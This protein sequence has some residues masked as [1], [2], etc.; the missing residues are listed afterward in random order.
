MS[1]TRRSILTLLTA[2]MVTLSLSAR[3]S[4]A[5]QQEVSVT[6]SLP[7]TAYTGDTVVM[8]VIIRGTQEAEPPDVPPSDSYDIRYLRPMT[9]SQVVF[10]TGSGTRVNSY[11]VHEYAFTP[12]RTGRI[13]V[14]P[15]R[16]VVDGKTYTAP[17]AT[18]NVVEPA[19]APEF[20]LTLTPEKK[21]FYVGEPIRLRLELTL[22]R[23]IRTSPLRFQLPSWPDGL[24][25]LPHPDHPR[26]ANDQTN[27]PSFDA[28][29]NGRPEVAVATSTDTPA[30][31]SRTLVFDWIV[32]ARKPGSFTLDPARAEFDVIV[33][34]RPS[35]FMDFPGTDRTIAER[36]I[37]RAAPI[38]LV[39]LPLPAEGRPADFSGLVGRYAIDSR[40]DHNTVSVGEPMNLAVTISGPPPISL[41]PVFDFRAQDSL[42]RDFRVTR[43]PVLPAQAGSAAAR[44]EQ[45]IR[46]RSS[47]IAAVPPIELNFF[48]PDSGTYQTARSQPIPITV[49]PSDSVLLD[50]EEPPTESAHSQVFSPSSQVRAGPFAFT[51]HRFDPASAIRSPLS[52]IALA[53]PP[54][55]LLIGLAGRGV[56]SRRARTHALRR[57][58]RAVREAHRQLN[59]SSRAPADAVATAHSTAAALTNLAADWFDRPRRTLTTPEAFTLLSRASHPAAAALA[60]VLAECDRVRFGTES[61]QRTSIPPAETDLVTRA[62]TALTAA[63]ASLRE[64]AP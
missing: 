63:G 15:L 32:I 62:R 22:G 11:V 7:T 10:S 20:T 58:R 6:T 9:S 64:V 47:N 27:P 21:Q 37:A 23:G 43:D 17:A 33:G 53:G 2:I 61:A 35:R 8:Q 24:E 13:T 19:E 1:T 48:D 5:Q 50:D 3:S 44:F 4:I 51:G 31:P 59:R 29:V 30:G 34:E 36:R 41:I 14:P 16:I 28:V 45:T 42:V 18:V 39:V 40:I 49:K 52:L 26:T 57:R 54:T 46:A 55:L 12:R 60:P 38:S 25:R 56:A